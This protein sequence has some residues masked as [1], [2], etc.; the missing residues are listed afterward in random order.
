[1]ILAS[2]WTMNYATLGQFSIQWYHISSWNFQNF[3]LRPVSFPRQEAMIE[4]FRI[5]NFLLILFCQILLFLM[6][7]EDF[8]FF[9][10]RNFYNR[11][12]WLPKSTRLRIY[13]YFIG[14]IR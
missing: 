14:L 4:M 6:S 8:K 1:M 13:T 11:N 12:F 7:E 9:L 3:H 2:N 10:S 5:R